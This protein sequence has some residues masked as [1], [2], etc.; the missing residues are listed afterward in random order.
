MSSLSFHYKYPTKKPGVIHYPFELK[1]N[2]LV[3]TFR[4]WDERRVIPAWVM[5]AMIE[6][7][8]SIG[9]L[10]LH[11]AKFNTLF[12]RKGRVQYFSD[13]AFSIDP[14]NYYQYTILGGHTLYIQYD[15]G[16][17]TIQ[18]IPGAPL[19]MSASH[20][21]RYLKHIVK[22]VKRHYPS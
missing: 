12:T 7:Q 22:F 16:F 21:C 9:S 10:H 20:F 6:S 15:K 19:I 11:M 14:V 5:G 8:N 4:M 18:N 2:Y 3:L 13:F 17:D 1:D